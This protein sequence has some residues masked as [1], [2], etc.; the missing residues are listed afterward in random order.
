MGKGWFA[1]LLVR[2]EPHASTKDAGQL[3]PNTAL[4][5][6]SLCFALFAMSDP[7]GSLRLKAP[8]PLGAGAL[9]SGRTINLDVRSY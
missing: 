6:K 5:G 9:T 8:A 3:M 4:P 1:S 2:G 7:Q